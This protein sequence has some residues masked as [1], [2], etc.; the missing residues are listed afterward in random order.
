MAAT[1]DGRGRGEISP[2]RRVGRRGEQKRRWDRENR[3]RCRC[4]GPV[5]RGAGLC[6]ICENIERAQLKAR[7]WNE[8][9][10]LWLAGLTLVEIGERLGK[11][12]AGVS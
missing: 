4:G 1:D 6:R 9:R 12:W 3:A 2:E 5:T 7:K 8:I 10:D 11:A